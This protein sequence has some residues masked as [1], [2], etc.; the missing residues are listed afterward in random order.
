[1]HIFPVCLSLPNFRQHELSQKINKLKLQIEIN[2]SSI[3]L[4]VQ[5]NDYLSE[6]LP[7]LLQEKGCN[8]TIV[9]TPSE[10]DYTVTITAKFKTCGEPTKYKEVYCYASASAVINNSKVQKPVNVNIPEAKGGWTN[11]NKE[12]ATEEAFKELTNSLAEKISQTIN[13]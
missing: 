7:D 3:Y 12:K 2:T 10:V 6:N 4:K 9:K 5:G 13:Q 1:M 11:G 8:C